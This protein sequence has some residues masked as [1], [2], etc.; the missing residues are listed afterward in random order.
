[1][2]TQPKT[3]VAVLGYGCHLNP[4]M[5]RYLNTVAHFVNIN[6]TEKIVLAGGFTNSQSAPGI[7]EAGMM[8]QYLKR[9]ISTQMILEES[10]RT[11]TENLKSIKKVIEEQKL[12]NYSL[13]IFCDSCRSLKVRL[14]A[15]F[16][17]G[18]WPQIKTYQL[19]KS[20]IQRAK[21]I[22]L[23]TPLDCLAFWIPSLEK[24]EIKR[25]ENLIIKS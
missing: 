3:I 2:L 15:R 11:T 24:M 7:S 13:I 4:G 10:S 1:M 9:K 6:E 21:Q 23:A 5:E 19:T 14:I 25:K 22:L 17:F 12:E 18:F 20:L 8:Q 16:T